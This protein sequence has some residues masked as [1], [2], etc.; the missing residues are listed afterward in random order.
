MKKKGKIGIPRNVLALKVAN[1]V[2]RDILSVSFCLFYLFLK[3]EKRTT[4]LLCCF[5][6]MMVL[7]SKEQKRIEKS[8]NG[9]FV[10]FNFAFS[11]ILYKILEITKTVEIFS[12]LNL[13][14]LRQN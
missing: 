7:E 10:I 3:N 5:V 8:Y 12:S 6:L 14:S 1:F 13:T 4:S 11:H 9:I 2:A